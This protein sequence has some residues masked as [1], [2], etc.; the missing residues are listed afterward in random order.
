RDIDR[1]RAN[2]A[3]A[4]AGRGS[5]GEYRTMCA[6]GSS[7]WMGITVRPVPTDA[8][9]ARVNSLRDIEDEVTARTN[10]EF[11]LG[12]DQM[13]SLPTIQAMVTRLEFLLSI[14]PDGDRLALLCIGIDSL[15]K[16]N[17]ALTFAAGDI[18]VKVVA[19]RIV[20]AV[21]MADA[22]GRGTGDEFLV[23]AP[24][25]L[26]DADP[27]ATAERIRAALR[28]P[29]I[30]QG[31]DISTTVS[32]G[33]AFADAS[34]QAH[35]LLSDASL[36][37]RQAKDA[38][39]DR[40]AFLDPILAAEAQRRLARE[41]EIRRAITD[42]EIVPWFQP[43]VDFSTGTIVGYE[44]LARWIRPD[45][46]ESPDEFIPLC[47][48]SDC[49]H[50]L[51]AVVLERAVQTLS[52]LDDGVFIAVNVS[53]STLAGAAYADHVIRV[54]SRCGVDAARLHLEVTE[55]ALLA[56]EGAVREAM[57]RLAAE[58]VSWYVDDFGTGYSSISHLR[59]LPIVGLKLDLSFTRG[60]GDGDE[61]S[62]RL[63]QAL[64][65]LAQGLGLDTVAEGVE[66]AAEAEILSAQGW[67]H[68][69]GWLYGRP[70]PIA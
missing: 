60:I 50:D 21:G 57:L 14:M 55:T 4:L 29:I 7:R 1:A 5:Y 58:G 9:M 40:Y 59:D 52:G 47:E 19:T 41:A 45:G 68:G 8:G 30:V 62:V 18:V 27:V 46:V 48:E 36:A 49:I 34:M 10:L 53:S 61:T 44:A 64:S 26:S 3:E 63:A 32:I 11:A 37:L 22:V 2:R 54:L 23:M 17:D 31:Q 6:D 39:R 28:D 70:A 66:S 20:N 15:A 65:G 24:Y 12:H 69:Q 56:V 51:D 25:P 38:G 42:G 16:V 43:I 67:K 35:Q 13:T 33:I